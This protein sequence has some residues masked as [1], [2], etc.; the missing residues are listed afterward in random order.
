MSKRVVLLVED[1]PGDQRLTLEAW[2]EAAPSGELV[3]VADG[4]EALEYLRGTGRFAGRPRPALVL[5]DLNLPRRDGREVLMELKSDPELRATPVIV[6]TTS[7]A[8]LDIHKSYDSHANC[9][10]T[11]PADW[12][13]LVKVLRS[14]DNFWLRTVELPA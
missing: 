1:N 7:K 12:E 6:L 2:R 8:D 5:L 4:V 14:I 10:I 9:Y 13:S 11:K 3:V